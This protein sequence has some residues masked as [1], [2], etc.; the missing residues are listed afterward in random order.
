MLPPRRLIGS[1]GP[2]T[3]ETERANSRGPDAKPEAALY[4]G[5]MWERLWKNE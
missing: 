4:S 1:R 5:R 3:F 2:G